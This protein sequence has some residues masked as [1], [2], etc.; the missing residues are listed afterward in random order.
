MHPVKFRQSLFTGC[1]EVENVLANQKPG[2]SSFLTDPVRFPQIPFSGCK[3]EVENI[4]TYQMPGRLSLLTDRHENHKLGRGHWVLASFHVKF[5]LA[6]CESLTTD[7]GIGI[8]ESP[9]CD[10]NPQPN[11]RGIG[12]LVGRTSGNRRS[13]MHV[14]V[15]IFSIT[16]N[17]S[18][19]KVC[20]LRRKTFLF[21]FCFLLRSADVRRKTFLFLLCFLLL[22]LL[23]FLIFL[24][25]RFSP[26]I[27]P[28]F[29]NRSL[30]NLACW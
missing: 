22:F 6:V 27:S 17:F 8:F 3:G 7:D 5:R 15:E 16:Y 4:S 18:I 12:P 14:L 29:L 30:S 13:V 1:R 10:V 9:K 26:T 21:L 25:S 23:F 11:T 24:Y 19:I 2:W 28:L 20:R